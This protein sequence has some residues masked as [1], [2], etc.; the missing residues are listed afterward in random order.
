MGRQTLTHGP[1]TH[2]KNMIRLTHRSMTHRPMTDRPIVS[3]GLYS[4][5]LYTVAIL[6]NVNGN[7]Y[8]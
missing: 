1:L 5:V 3:S 7:I 6:T 4:I 2:T 8:K